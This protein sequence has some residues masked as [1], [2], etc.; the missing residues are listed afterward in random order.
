MENLFLN[1]KQRIEKEHNLVE[2]LCL[3]NSKGVI[4]KEQY[5]PRNHR[6]S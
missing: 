6:N 2:A 4:W 5:I 1:F 3:S